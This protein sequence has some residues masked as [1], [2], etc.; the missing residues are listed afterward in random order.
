MLQITVA[1][2]LRRDWR[3]HLVYWQ[4]LEKVATC[5]SRYVSSQKKY[6]VIN[7]VIIN[8]GWGRKINNAIENWKLVL[9]ASKHC[10]EHNPYFTCDVWDISNSSC[11]FGW[12]FVILNKI[13]D[14]EKLICLK[15]SLK[16][17]GSCLDIFTPKACLV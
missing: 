8:R 9:G 14:R 13:V 1:L 4:L 15:M 17:S 2:I 6:I 11:V 3:S 10:C 5:R 7:S 16:W 12:V